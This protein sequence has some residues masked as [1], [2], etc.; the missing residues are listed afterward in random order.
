MK[1]SAYLTTNYIG[2]IANELISYS[3][4]ILSAAV[5]LIVGFYAIRLIKKVSQKILSNREIDPTLSKFLTDILLWAL[6]GLLFVSVISKLGIETTSFVAILGSIGLA[7]G[8]SLQGSLANFAGGMLIILFK[9]F[10]VGHTIQA[11]N[12]LGTVDEIQIFVT[13]LIT[14]DNQTIFIPNALLSNG[15]ITNYSLGNTRKADLTFSVAYSTDIKVAKDIIETS[16]NSNTKILKT[17]APEV[18]VKSLTDNAIVLSVKPWTKNE[19]FAEVVGQVLEDC[20]TAFDVAGIQIQ[21]TP[22]EIV[23]NKS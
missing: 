22:K 9:P 21:P 15:I 17:P 6:R 1:L 12:M 8:L 10:R 14:A 13:K 18:F 19:D 11:H 2:K 5:L 16:L 3:P 23:Q 4:K 7:I 20:K